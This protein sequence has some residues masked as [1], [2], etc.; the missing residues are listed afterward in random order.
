MVSEVLA[1]AGEPWFLDS[2]AENDSGRMVWMACDAPLWH[3]E[4]ESGRKGE[5]VPFQV[6]CESQLSLSTW[7]RCEPPR[8]RCFLWLVGVSREERLMEA[9]NQECR[10]Q[11]W[12]TTKGKREY[13]PDT[14]L[15]LFLLP[16]CRSMLARFFMV[17]LSYLETLFI[18]ILQKNL[19]FLLVSCSL[20]F[21]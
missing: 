11:P 14:S 2:E 16:E 4:A 18:T 10:I 8:R 6:T 7:R 13:E 3:K 20:Y 17:L 19:L 9:G 1:P 21:F 5:G 15:N 12:M